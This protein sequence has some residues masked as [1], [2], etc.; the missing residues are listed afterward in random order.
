MI[1][2]ILTIV[3]VAPLFWLLMGYTCVSYLYCR[4]IVIRHWLFYSI[5]STSCDPVTPNQCWIVLL[6]GTNETHFF[7]LHVIKKFPDSTF[8][9]V[10]ILPSISWY[11]T[12]NWTSL[13]V[14]QNNTKHLSIQ[15]PN[16]N[17]WIRKKSVLPTK[18][19][20]YFSIM[21]LSVQIAILLI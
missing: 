20:Y 10:T 1:K 19:F 11:M 3:D 4:N 14:R 13:V 16:T 21:E 12:V 5:A 8:L 17:R 6:N 2:M 18:M 9:N 7:W 15:R